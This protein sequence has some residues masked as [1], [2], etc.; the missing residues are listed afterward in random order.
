MIRILESPDLARTLSKKGLERAREFSG[1]IY[2]TKVYD[3]LKEVEL[4]K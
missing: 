1:D 3:L 4:Y 2:A